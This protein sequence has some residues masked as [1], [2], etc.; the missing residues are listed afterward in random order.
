MLQTT[1]YHNDIIAIDANFIQ[2]QLVAVHMLVEGNAAAIIDT[3]VNS[4]AATVMAAIEHYGLTPE[5]VEYVILT[6]VHLDHA[7]G[8]GELM[9]RFP[10]A[11]LVV[12]PR[13]SRHMVDPSQLIEGTIGVYGE[14]RTNRL[15]GTILPVERDRIIEA[16]HEAV[17]RLGKR[18]LLLLHTPGHALHHIAIVDR[19]TGH[20]FSGDTF[21]LSYRQLDNRGRQ[22]IFPTTTPV[23]FDPEALHQ[24]IDLL[25]SLAPEAI[26]LTHYSQIHDIPRLTSDL[27]AAIDAH[28]DIAQKA[29]GRGQERIEAIEQGLADWVREAAKRQEWGLQG[30][31]AL[32]RLAMDIGL[33]AQGMNV[34]LERAK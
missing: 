4:S 3:G 9:R 23:Q 20:I 8:A 33:N 1:D 29:G 24:S 28:V 27:K 18:E 19:K 25:A 14:E 10:R 6:H 17:I 30:E 32:A 5:Q 11:R 15:Y 13:G 21:G 22:F 34:W 31:D 26:Y 16:G 7:G 12:H 2:P